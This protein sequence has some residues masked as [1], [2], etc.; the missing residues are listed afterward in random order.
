M[1]IVDLIGWQMPIT[2]EES[3]LLDR[4]KDSAV[5]EHKTL[6][7]REQLLASQ[8]VNRDVLLRKNQNGQ[9]LYKT[10]IKENTSH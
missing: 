5:I 6:N 1:R 3:E 9:I 7:Q 4:F 8:L 10:K 2:N